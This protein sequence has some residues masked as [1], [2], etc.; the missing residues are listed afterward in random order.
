MPRHPWPPQ[1]PPSFFEALAIHTQN[2]AGSSDATAPSGTTPDSVGDVA[3]RV[4]HRLTDGCL[5][6]DASLRCRF[7]NAAVQPLL[8]P[9]IRPNQVEDRAWHEV[10]SPDWLDVL[11]PWV[12]QAL[13]NEP[14]QFQTACPGCDNA[15]HWSLTVLPD[16][17]DGAVRGV[18]ILLRDDSAWERH[19]AE[20]RAQQ[21]DLQ[22]QLQHQSAWLTLQHARWQA[23]SD[24][25][26]DA[27]LFFLDSNG[28][29]IDWP[30]SAQRLLGY[31]AS[32]VL[33][34]AGPDRPDAPHPLPPDAAQALER[35]AL[36]G[37]SEATLWLRCADGQRLWAH[38]VYAALRG[39]EG[40]PLGTACLV[41]D[42]TE[43]RR[44]EELLRD[45]NH[46]LERKVEERT[47]QLHS[48]NQDLEAFSYS[49]S[50]D[51]RAPLR[52]ISAYVQVLREDLRGHIAQDVERD[53]RTIENAAAHMHRLIE[54][55]LAFARLGRAALQPQPLNMLSLVHSS[56]HRVQ[57]DPAL[58]RPPGYGVEVDIPHELPNVEGDALLL[59]QVWDNLLA[60]AFK[61]TRKQPH[62]RIAVG[63]RVQPG[64]QGEE[65][66]FWV[67][68]NGVGFDPA[69]AERL[70][71][72]FQRLH[73][74]QDFE[75]TGIGLALCRRIIERHGGRIWADAR[76]GEGA[77]FHFALPLRAA[78]ATDPD[79]HETAAG[80]DTDGAATD[81]AGPHT[82]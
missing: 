41:R 35:A 51:L 76:P 19:A 60:N 24:G 9:G 70:F 81:T 49:V 68:D 39:A 27:A 4:L 46:A 58:Q 3:V 13:R 61:Y 12:A 34:T 33:G 65:A 23:L 80:P 14:G 25:L 75:G 79:A 43:M 21:A 29:I 50:H 20:L 36:L 16:T 40:E 73:R 77:T 44:L 5:I 38:V 66:V 71:G 53:L 15:A 28:A 7:A 62:A 22:Q 31:P 30:A 48:L 45:L 2:C 10:L 57:H 54:G 1:L 63:G 74:A 78:P 72:V 47:R 11:L 55:L 26:R 82:G 37:Q 32:A 64:P 52:H 17:V 18:C 69:R 42:M 56:L 6:L 67:E 8:R 59:S